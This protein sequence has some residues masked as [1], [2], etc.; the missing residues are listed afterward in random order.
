MWK[1]QFGFL[2]EFKILIDFQATFF[3]TESTW[4]LTIRDLTT[5]F[6]GSVANKSSTSPSNI[7]SNTIGWEKKS[8][9]CIRNKLAG[10]QIAANRYRKWST[11][12]RKSLRGVKYFDTWLNSIRLTL[13]SSSTTFFPW[14][15]HNADTTKKTSLN[16][17][18][19]PIS[20]A[21]FNFARL[22]LT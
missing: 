5:Q 12:S 6:T 14:W 7:N 19:F 22:L 15:L 10:N 2:R 17:K 18:T 11:P 1:A 20:F 9:L 4:K 16:C 3:R 13:A 21:V 8:K